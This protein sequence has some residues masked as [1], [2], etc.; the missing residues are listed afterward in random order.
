MAKKPSTALAKVKSSNNSHKPKRSG[1]APILMKNGHEVRHC[2]K[3]HKRYYRG[4][5]A[6]MWMMRSGVFVQVFVYEC[7]DCLKPPQVQRFLM[8]MQLPPPQ[9]QIQKPIAS[10]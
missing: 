8:N 7:T 6:R 5:M 4:N 9:F 10:R 2:D 3:C 1:P